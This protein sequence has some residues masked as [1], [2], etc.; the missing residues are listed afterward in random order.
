MTVVGASPDLKCAIQ[1]HLNQGD[2]GNKIHEMTNIF[3]HF[4]IDLV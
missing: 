4:K 3:D 1:H 2:S